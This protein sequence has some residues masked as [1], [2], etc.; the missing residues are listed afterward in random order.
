MSWTSCRKSARSIDNCQSSASLRVVSGAVARHAPSRRANVGAALATCRGHGGSC[1]VYRAGCPIAVVLLT[2][3]VVSRSSGLGAAQAPGVSLSA[4]WE[5]PANLRSRDLFNG[6]WGAA[7]A[8]G[9][10]RDVYVRPAQRGKR[11]QPGSRRSRS[12]RAR[13]YGTSSSRSPRREGKRGAEG[14]GGGHR[15]TRASQPW[16]FTS[17]RCKAPALVYDDRF[18]RRASRG[19]R[20]VPRLDEPSLQA[21]GNWRVQR[22]IR[23]ASGCANI[24]A[25]SSCS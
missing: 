6:P 19:R 8:R 11:R 2:T 10:P 20:T 22:T 9:S 7:N 18:A 3:L 14:A 4:L 13:W 5:A 1:D 12:S 15:F 17:R 23:S 21:R 25:F 24:G 16:A